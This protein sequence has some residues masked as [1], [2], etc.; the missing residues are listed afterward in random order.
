MDYNEQTDIRALN[1]KIVV[2][3]QV[4]E[5]NCLQYIIHHES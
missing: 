2:N 5:L 3:A 4:A 1:S